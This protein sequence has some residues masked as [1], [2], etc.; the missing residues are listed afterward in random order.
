M[1]EFDFANK[2]ITRVLRMAPDGIRSQK[3]ARNV[4]SMMV[5]AVE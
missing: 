2:A 4:V 1:S 3:I 5:R